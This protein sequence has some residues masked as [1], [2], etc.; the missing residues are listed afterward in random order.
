MRVIGYVRV[1][2]EEQASQG[3]SLDHQKRV[4]ADEVARRGWD[5]SDMA[6]DTASAGSMKRRPGLGRALAQLDQGVYTTLIVARL[7]RL[8][9]SVGDFAQMM[10]RAQRQG[11]QIVVMDPAVDMTSPFGEAMASM[12]AVFAQLERKLIAQ[13]TR[14]GI[15]AKKAAG[16]YRGGRM[17]PQSQPVDEHATRRILALSG[18]GL[19]SRKIAERLNLEGVPTVRGGPW[20]H[21]T[22]ITVLRRSRSVAA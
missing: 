12:A 15:A 9:R 14:D 4:I 13:R 20:I 18:Q 7:D 6:A 5:L 19:S 3:A 22:I 21:S 1:S 10:D 2:T 8:S 11:W 17:L 16:T